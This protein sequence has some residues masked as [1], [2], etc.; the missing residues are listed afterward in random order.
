LVH[1]I[2]SQRLASYLVCVSLLLTPAFEKRRAS[3]FQPHITV[4][5]LPAL[6]EKEG[7]LSLICTHDCANS[8][9]SGSSPVI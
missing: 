9:Y 2:F 5:E 6:T 3:R 7:S 1:F 4:T 8:R